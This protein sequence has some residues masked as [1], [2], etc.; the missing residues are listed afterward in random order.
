VNKFIHLHRV[1]CDDCEAPIDTTTERNFII[2]DPW[3]KPTGEIW[4]ENCQ[5]KRWQRHQEYL[6]ET[7]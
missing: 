3:G 7:T 5:E 2:R 4:C 6:M 1:R